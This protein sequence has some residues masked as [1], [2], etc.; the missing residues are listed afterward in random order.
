MLLND[1]Q[2]GK[3]FFDFYDKEFSYVGSL[4]LDS[5][6]SYSQFLSILQNT[7]IA[8]VDR[9]HELI[10]FIANSEIGNVIK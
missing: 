10:I 3:G 2:I 8:R 7:D 1:E 9:H 5:S 4:R 6:V